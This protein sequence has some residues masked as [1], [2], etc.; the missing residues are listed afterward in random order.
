M[1]G[2]KIEVIINPDGSVEGEAIGYEGDGCI[3]EL[4]GL[5]SGMGSKRT[6][7]KSDF[8]RKTKISAGDMRNRNN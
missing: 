5:T 6:K 1:S 3:K 8:F 7:R 2:K 4:R